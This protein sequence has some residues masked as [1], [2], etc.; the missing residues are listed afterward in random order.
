MIMRALAVALAAAAAVSAAEARP[1][2]LAMSCAEAAG[3]VAARGAVVLS[4]GRHTYDRF[5]AHAGYCQ[6]DEYADRAFAPTRSGQCRLGYVCRPGPPPWEDDR[7]F[8][9]IP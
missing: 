1:S 2:T 8:L 7:L 5:V 4:T 6:P 9:D 3:L